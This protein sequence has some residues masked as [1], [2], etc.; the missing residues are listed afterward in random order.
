MAKSIIAQANLPI[1]FRGDVILTTAYILNH[2]PSKSIPST[3]YELWHSRKPNLQSLHPWGS[4]GFM[5]STSHKYGNLDPS[6]YKLIFIRYCDHSKGYVMFGE[7]RDKGMTEIESGDVD[8]LEEDF[9]S[10]SEIK[11]NLELYE[12]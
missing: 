9:P 10:L 1:S 4:T 2:V 7:H 6:A 8:F 12:L 5:H 11:G 3:L